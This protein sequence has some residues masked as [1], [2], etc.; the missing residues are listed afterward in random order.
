MRQR[1]KFTEA[2]MI[3]HKDGIWVKTTPL[4]VRAS[5]A[6]IGLFDRATG[7]DSPIAIIAS[8]PDWKLKTDCKAMVAHA[9]YETNFADWSP[10]GAFWGLK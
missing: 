2:G 1:Y 8:H 6:M 3:P 5:E 10:E 9:G 4:E 7:K